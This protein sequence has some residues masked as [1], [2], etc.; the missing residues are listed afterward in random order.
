M[1]EKFFNQISKLDDLISKQPNIKSLT[2]F[3]NLTRNSILAEYAYKNLDSK[4]WLIALKEKNVFSKPPNPEKKGDFI[5]YPNWPEMDYLT[6]MVLKDEI[7]VCD[8]ILDI[9]ETDNFTV[10]YDILDIAEKLNPE[11]AAKIMV[12]ELDYLKNQEKIHILYSHRIGHI[13][14]KLAKGNK[15]QAA[16][17]LAKIVLDIKPDPRFEMEVQDSFL[18]PSPQLQIKMDTHDYSNILKKHMPDLVEA[19][20]M[21]TF[22]LL[23]DLLY[24]AIKYSMVNKSEKEGPADYSYIWRPAIEDHEENTPMDLQEILVESVRDAAIRLMPKY[25]LKILR[26]LEAQDRQYVIFKRIAMH[27]RRKWSNLDKQNTEN[28]IIDKEICEDNH[29]KYELYHLLEDRFEQFSEKTKDEYLKLVNSG[30]GAIKT[31][32]WLQTEHKKKFSKSE[33]EDR[34]RRWKYEK[35]IPIQKYLS[36]DWNSTYIKYKEEFGSSENPDLSYT[37]GVSWVGPTSP[38]EYEDISNKS[39]EELT[40]YLILWQ[41]SNERM[42]PSR[43]GLARQIELMV[44]D[45]PQKFTEKLSLFHDTKIDPVYIRDIISGFREAIKDKKQIEWEQVIEFLQWVMAQPREVSEYKS[46][47]NDPGFVFAR[48]RTADLLEHGFSSE[49]TEI[50]EKFRSKIW[51]II[52]LL[53]DD[54]DPTIEE[55]RP[56]NDYSSMSINTVSGQAMHATIRYGLWVRRKQENQVN[57]KKL[58]EEGFV[59]IPELRDLLNLKLDRKKEPRLTIRSVYGKWFPWLVLLDQKWAEK[60]VNV[61]FPQDHEYENYFFS[62]WYSYITFTRAFD[63]VFPIL[64]HVYDYAIHKIQEMDDDNQMY[65]PSESLVEHL[66]V[67]SLRGLIEFKEGSLLDKFFNLSPAKIKLHIFDYSGL[68]L[69]NSEGTIPDDMKVKFIELWDWLEK[70]YDFN[71]LSEEDKDSL[72]WFGIWVASDILEINWVIEKLLNVLQAGVKVEHD[73]DVVEYLSKVFSDFPFQTLECL[74]LMIINHK[75]RYQVFWK[76]DARKILSDALINDNFKVREKAEEVVN[77]F[78]ALGYFDFGDLLK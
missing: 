78:G 47:Y 60:H 6:R 10:H 55:D 7:L 5:Q 18:S 4:E 76:D 65:K 28:L 20:E 54:P 37:H 12:K 40:Q 21:D 16:L 23:I 26:Y 53:T 2:E 44:K 61:I 3:L 75:E 70:K 14:S 9:Q 77:Q 24:K 74:N 15:I 58:V 39:I 29:F 30:F 52:R 49:P 25:G 43:E 19:G 35:L 71:K 17:K 36:D 31:I 63:N 8:T 68:L 41:P 73:K 48:R 56:S 34:I 27:L 11:L 22:F 1:P 33:K 38:K 46:E 59:H 66:V 72:K 64:K 45:N 67:Y 51:E 57:F 32:E 62:A 50:P 13:L 42:A 69:L